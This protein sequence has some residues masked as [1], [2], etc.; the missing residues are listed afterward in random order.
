MEKS[1]E[2]PSVQEN[3]EGL[4]KYVFSE[5][6]GTGVLKLLPRESQGPE[7]A[8]VFGCGIKDS[9]RPCTNLFSVGCWLWCLPPDCC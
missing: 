7:P 8:A 9:Q 4:N 6:L 2:K 1:I 5:T 3:T